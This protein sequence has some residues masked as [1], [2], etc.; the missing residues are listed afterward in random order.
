[1]PRDASAVILASGRGRRLG[2]G[3]KAL[4]PLGGEAM[5]EHSLRAFRS[6]ASVAEIV[7]VLGADDRRAYRDRWGTEPAADRI[8]EGGAERWLS[9]RA[10]CEATRTECSFVAVHDS[11]RPLIEAP[12]IE[13]VLAA[14]RSHGAAL[15]AAPLA[16]TLKRAD[17]GQRAA[18]T[19]PREGLWRAQTPQAA[20]RDW[21]LGAFQAWPRSNEAPTDEARLLEEGGRHPILVPA[22]STNLKVTTAADLELAEALLAQRRQQ[23]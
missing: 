18:G 8:V 5:L 15:A 3:N 6:A 7:L 23:A 10:G 13:A 14:A 1:M 9:S 21:L 17:A 19:L 2:S 11:A 4:L 16:D 12:T 20:R 22:P